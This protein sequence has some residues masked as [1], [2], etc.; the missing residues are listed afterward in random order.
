MT[1]SKPYDGLQVR[2]HL[3]NDDHDLR[4]TA[5][6]D[7]AGRDP[8]E[9]ASQNLYSCRGANMVYYRFRFE[10][11]EYWG[12]RSIPP[13]ETS[14]LHTALPISSRWQHKWAPRYARAHR[15][16]TDF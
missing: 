9:L 5:P 7:V 15:E 10:G 14:A 8:V 12:R 13:G 1:E 11:H 3:P 16:R 6:D 4:I 2:I